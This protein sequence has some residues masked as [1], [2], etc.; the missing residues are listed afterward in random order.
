[1]INKINNILN[2]VLYYE[3]LILTSWNFL[4]FFAHKVPAV[5]YSAT[6]IAWFD[7]WKPVMS[8][9]IAVATPYFKLLALFGSYIFQ[10]SRRFCFCSIYVKHSWPLRRRAKVIL[11]MVIVSYFSECKSRNSQHFECTFIPPDVL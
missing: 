4:P 8:L 3:W 5:R 6:C 11:V 9:T 2:C 10:V 7:T 1:M